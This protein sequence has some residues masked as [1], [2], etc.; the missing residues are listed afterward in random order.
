MIKRTVSIDFSRKNGKLK[1][2]NCLNNGPRFGMDLE[3][4]FTEQYKEMAPQFVRLSDVEAPFAASRYL[5]IHCIF[6]DF[7]LDERFEASY[8]FGPT[9]RL[10]SAVKDSGAD[11]FLRLGESRE[12]YE[13]AK[14]T[15]M[16]R[17]PEKYAR[18]CEKI[19]AHYN[20]RWANGFKYNI[21][22][23]EI[24]PDVDT[25]AGWRSS[26]REYYELYATVAN[27]I[28]SV[29]PKIKVGGYSS[30]GFFSLNHYNG[31][32]EE[33]S[34]IDFLENFLTYITR[35]N[36]APLDFF[37]WKCYAESPEEISLH[38]NYAKSYL[39]Q[40]G[41]KKT[42]SVI[43]EFNL[44]DTEKGAFL[45]RKYPS[46]FARAMIIA[47]KSNVDMMFY[48]HLDPASPYNS[49]YALNHRCDKHFYAAYHVM[50]AFG[51]LSSL[52]GVVDSTEDYRTE[53][54]SLAAMGEKSGACVFSTS[55][56]SGVVE[57]RVT[58][59]EYTNYSIK[60]IIG[61][62]DEGC[63]FFTEERGLPLK[64][65]TVTLRVGKNEV[66]FLTFS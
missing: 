56:Y 51:A 63:G 35:E 2:V 33:K 43:S 59:R 52:D 29:F 46:A 13:I 62:G 50:T 42:Q 6:P 17:D 39:G 53:I 22:Y 48:S 31:T 4:D 60:G 15:K 1:P 57:I 9:D 66:Y 64:N 41:L 40:Y 32:P 26:P 23:V 18:I 27:H 44:K 24:F 45:E 34:Y 19:I 21:K 12:P 55:D 30:G 28:K 61:G 47:Q 11:I 54:Y 38:A 7:D 10:L 16:P 20:T 58:G 3:L 36:K 25:S 8:N 37:S 65:N 5:D 14:Y 49:L